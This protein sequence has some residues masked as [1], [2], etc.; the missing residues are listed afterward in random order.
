M[1]FPRKVDYT[2]IAGVEVWQ[3]HWHKQE[4]NKQL[5]EVEKDP[6]TMIVRKWI[7][8]TAVGK[9]SPKILDGGCGIGRYLAYFSKLGYDITG[10][11]F[12]PVAVKSAK[13][14]DPNLKILKASVLELPFDSETFNYYLSFGVLEHFIDGP[15]QGLKESHRV[16]RKDGMLFL[17]VPYM[18]YL[19]LLEARR[20]ALMRKSPKR[21]DGSGGHF[22]Q[23]YF[24]KEELN[25]LLASHGFEVLRDYP[26]NQELGLLRALPFF[27]N[28]RVLNYMVIKLAKISRTIAPHICAH[29]ILLVCRKVA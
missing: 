29:K 1:G 14:F 7:E 22:Y 21:Q 26:L 16:L 4:F 24:T 10:V 15:E 13:D 12:S 20:D 8:D 2:R 23:Y 3:E 18:N 28:K 25:W 27:R 6:V 9:E 11:D 17:S 19:R 5:S